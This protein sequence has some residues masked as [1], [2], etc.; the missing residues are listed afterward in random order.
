MR[1]AWLGKRREHP[2]PPI[3]PIR[4]AARGAVPFPETFK[5]FPPSQK[6]ASFTIDQ[7]LAKMS[8]VASG[9]RH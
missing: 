7:A 6:A 8:E 3:Q 2:R 4:L 9:A 1:L 5:E